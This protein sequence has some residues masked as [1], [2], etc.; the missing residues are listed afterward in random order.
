MSKARDLANLLGGGGS[1]VPSFSGTGAID[2]PAGTTEQRPSNPNTGYV[3]FNT[4]LDQLEQ[5]T[6]DSGWQGISPPPVATSVSPASF[7]G[8]SGTT[9][10]VTGANFDTT[11]TVRFITAGG[12]EYSAATV[13]R[14][15]SSEIV[16]TTPRNFSVSEEPLSVKV[17]NGSGLSASVE[18]AIDCGGVPTWS[19][20][21]GTIATINDEY[22]NYSPIATLSASDPEGGA[23]SYTVTSGAV[24]SGTTLNGS[25]GQISGNPANVANQTT[26]NF[27]VAASDGVNTTT[28]SF[29][30]IVNPAQ[31]GSTSA[32]AAT[33][34]TSIVSLTGTSTNGMYW[35]NLDGTPRQF[36]CDMAGGG[37]I[38]ISQ[39][40]DSGGGTS[41]AS[42]NGGYTGAP[43]S[44]IA[45]PG[46]SDDLYANYG[47][48]YGN[49][50]SGSPW[51]MNGPM[52]L[53]T[54]SK[55]GYGYTRNDGNTDGAMRYFRPNN[56]GYSWSQIKWKFKIATNG[57]LDGWRNIPSY[58]GIDQPSCEGVQILHGNTTNRSHIYSYALANTGGGGEHQGTVAPYV[59]ASDYVEYTMANDGDAYN[60]PE[61]TRSIGTSTT[62]PPEIRL[63]TDQDA[64]INGSGNENV[65]LRA[66]YIFIK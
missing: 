7:N 3:R 23:V 10:T 32:K 9:F 15:N 63:G 39:F 57:S 55:M 22:G 27:S 26:S 45:L 11:A 42:N 17:I 25:T 41:Y 47:S 46:T 31:D 40:N 24:P 2:V 18:D 20:N 61:V 14:T 48:L 65:M 56:Y 16:A 13:S 66:W 59:G 51:S 30:I 53:L 36:F 49:L 28:R 38:L 44:G 19:T 1:G 58:T 5:Y 4:T 43:S 37:F 6:S 34:A 52:Q 35:L 54:D 50:S 8:D 62:I 12:A 29:S 21:S 33:S 64:Q 60:F